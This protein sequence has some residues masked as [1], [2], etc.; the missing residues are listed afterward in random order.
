MMWLILRLCA[1]LMNSGLRKEIGIYEH[2]MVI[3]LFPLNSKQLLLSSTDIIYTGFIS[4]LVHFQQKKLGAYL[5]IF[6][7]N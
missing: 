3:Y 2:M 4:I 7:D 5:M 6:D 1:T